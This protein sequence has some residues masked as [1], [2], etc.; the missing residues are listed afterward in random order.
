MAWSL[1]G[2]IR[3]GWYGQLLGHN[4]TL[5]CDTDKPT[6]LSC[7]LMA[8]K[9]LR[10]ANTVAYIRTMGVMG[11]LSIFFTTDYAL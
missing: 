6:M 8:H 3:T 2:T 10:A 5:L 9:M 1:W 7:N 11:A 4:D